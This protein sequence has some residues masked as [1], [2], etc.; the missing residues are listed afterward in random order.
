MTK[1][2]YIF[3]LI[4]SLITFGQPSHSTEE[5]IY[6]AV[7]NF[8]ANPNAENLKNLEVFSK[9]ISTTSN[10]K[11]EQLALVVLYCNKAYYENK[12][13]KTTNA[14]SSYEKAWQIYQK[15][16]LSNYDITEYCLKPLGNLYTIIG[17]YDNAEN[18]IK[19]YYYFATQEKS[20][21]QKYAAALNLSNVYQCSGRYFYAID[22]LEKTIKTERLTDAQKGNLW[23]NLG[24]NYL[25]RDINEDFLSAENAFLKAIPLLKNDKSQQESLSNIYLNLYKL[26]MKSTRN[27]GLNYY[28]KAK[29][30]FDNLPNKEPRKIAQFYLEKVSYLL[31]KKQYSEAQ[32]IIQSVYKILIPNYS[33]QKN[34]LPKQDNLY[35][36]T[37]LLDALDF[38]AELFVAEG[39]PQKALE[40]YALAFH[41]E[42]LFQTLLVYENSKII[43]QIRNR[44]RT[45]KCILIYQSLYENEPKESYIESAFQLAEKS[46]SLVLKE[47]LISNKTNSNEVKQAVEQLQNWN[48]I[49]QKEQQK[50]NLVNIATINEAI[51]KQNELMLDLKKIQN[52][53]EKT[54]NSA[55]N[56]K[57][58]F[59]KL[60]K[61]KTIMV[62]YFWGSNNVFSFT[63]QNN[64]ISLQSFCVGQMCG[65]SVIG[66]PSLFRD[67]NFIAENVDYYQKQAFLAYQ[68]LQLPKKSNYKNLIIIPDG[69]LNFL[70]FEALLTK[71]TATTNFA[72]MPYLLHN[73]S[74]GYNSSVT[75]YLNDVEQKR[76]NKKVLGIFP[77]FE[78]TDY[79]LTYSKKEMASIKDKFEGKYFENST[80]T[81]DN[82][83]KN[84][85][86]YS[87]LHLS[88]HASS[89]DIVSPASIKFYDQEILYSELY[90]LNINPDLVVLSAC[91]TGIGKLY[92]SEGAMSVARGF[93]FAGAKNLL[94]SLWKVN[95][96]T[97][98]VF[99]DKFYG[100]L[101]K[102]SSFLESNHQ[103]KLDFLADKTISNAKKSPYYW[104][105]FV[106]YGTLK[107][108]GTYN[109]Y[110]YYAIGLLI[111]ISL[112]LMY[113]RKRK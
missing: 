16:K 20:Q 19:H 54:P 79:A 8:T 97:T 25:L 24:S 83:K 59:A 112:F 80:A 57:Q 12:F 62:E 91:E 103:A 3:L 56:I 64:R 108:E 1:I 58:L 95:D 33:N 6:N 104:S 28:E 53:K 74:I 41:I 94:F 49:I 14:I 96:Y 106:Y 52:K 15:N 81:F 2:I 61:D 18:T 98:S 22:L 113:I 31:I 48:A 37:A 47:R 40:S 43:S 27:E 44:K 9:T 76:R 73:Y 4:L 82:F 60:E 66:F 93:Q 10:N 92:K 67:V 23:N 55:I 69:I 99:M 78:N 26:K 87:I 84:S 105:A 46:K 77:V 63:L 107:N 32:S 102:G 75:F 36:E 34:R 13:G 39:E 7:D 68:T 85:A 100:N 89:G 5:K 65:E 72:E 50:G 90:N 38:Q 42:E 17:D 29:T 101:K 88:T 35:A 21:S 51:N 30:I 86:N 111:L 70:P 71:K 11:K 45:E 109:N 110:I